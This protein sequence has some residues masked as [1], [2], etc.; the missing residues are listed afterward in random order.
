MPLVPAT[1]SSWLKA[2]LNSLDQRI[3]AL[4]TQ[5]NTFVLD[6]NAVQRLISG[7]QQ[8][9]GRYAIVALDATGN[10]RAVFGELADGRFGVAIYDENNDGGYIELNAPESASWNSTTLSTTST[11]DTTL[12]NS[13]S[14]TVSV[15]ASQ[16]CLVMVSAVLG[17]TAADGC[18]ATVYADGVSTG[19]KISLQSPSAVQ[20]TCANNLVVSGLAQGSHALTIEYRSVSGATANFGQIAITA[21]PY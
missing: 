9:D 3:T 2:Q 5:Q 15:G 14:L 10:R 6:N 16:K 1:S 12:A 13:P 7:W 18:V 11:T 4:S 20:S 8:S 19:P 21:I 17:N